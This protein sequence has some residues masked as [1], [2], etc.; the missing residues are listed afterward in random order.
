MNQLLLK[1]LFDF[2]HIPYPGI[3]LTMLYLSFLLGF[4]LLF[5]VSKRFDLNRKKIVF[6]PFFA[7]P[8]ALLGSKI[9]HFLFD[10]EFNFYVSNLYKNGFSY[11]F[12]VILNPFST[13]HVF[14]GGLF[15]GMFAGI[16][17]AYFINNKDVKKVLLTA[18]VASFPIA[19]GLSLTRIG[20]FFNGC[21][22]GIE[23]RL[24]GIRFPAN[25]VT[26]FVLHHMDKSIPFYEKTPPLIPTQIIHSFVNLAIFLYLIFMLKKSNVV[27][28]GFYFRK[29]LIFYSIGRFLIEFLRFDPRGHFLFFSTSQWFSL[30]VLLFIYFLDKK[31]LF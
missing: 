21:C 31:S 3:Y 14:F 7:I 30:V 28:P 23:S 20:C 6:L 25:S 2:L 29:F 27:F 22:F 5:L 1:P 4:P 10:E 24:L 26:S 13:G 18:D 9:F 16:F 12:T 17:Y 11:L 8:G 15:G 19:L